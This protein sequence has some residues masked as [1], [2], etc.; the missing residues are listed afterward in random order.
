MKTSIEN[1][2]FYVNEKKRMVTCVLNYY[3]TM[4]HRVES[5][6]GNLNKDFWPYKPFTSVGVAKC[7]KDDVFDVN[8]GKKVAQAK[9]ES[10]MYKDAADYMINTLAKFET[11]VGSDIVDF[12]DKADRT[13][14]HN[15]EYIRKF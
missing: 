8:I 7:D 3:Y 12:L 10:Q 5:F 14:A 6:V 2:K 13:I 4:D 15:D 1:F 11:H 9:A